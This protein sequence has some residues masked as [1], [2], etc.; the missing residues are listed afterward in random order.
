MPPRSN[1]TSNG[2]L[3]LPAPPKT[4][5]ASLAL[6]VALCCLFAMQAFFLGQLSPWP[7]L[8]GLLL[9]FATAVTGPLLRE[10]RNINLRG[11]LWFVPLT[12]VLTKA[13]F[14]PGSPW[15]DVQWLTQIGQGMVSLFRE[16]LL[17][18]AAA[19]SQAAGEISLSAALFLL[20][21][22]L[23]WGPATLA[24]R[25]ALRLRSW[26]WPVFTTLLLLVWLEPLPTSSFFFLPLV[27][28]AVAVFLLA[29][30]LQRRER[31]ESRRLAHDRRDLRRAL[32][33]SLLIVL[34]L[35]LLVIPWAVA[36]FSY[37]QLTLPSLPAFTSSSPE[38]STGGASGFPSIRPTGP[39]P[40]R[41]VP[42]YH[43]PPLDM[44]ES[45]TRWAVAASTVI[46]LGA[47]ALMGYFLLRMGKGFTVVYM[48]ATGAF[49]V[50]SLWLLPPVL[51][52]IMG[53]FFALL[54]EVWRGIRA[55]FGLPDPTAT[56]SVAATT[57]S[58]TTT[59]SGGTDSLGQFLAS[60]LTF[61]SRYAVWATILG[62]VI[63][64]LVA[65][66]VWR[67]IARTRLLQ[68]A[69]RKRLAANEPSQG[70]LPVGIF[71]LYFRLLA[72]LARMGW[73]RQAM[74]TPYEYARRASPALP[75]L[76]QPFRGIT[77]AFV[78]ARY[79]GREPEAVQEKQLGEELEQA[80]HDTSHPQSK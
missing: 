3:L 45:M 37:A 65:F 6:P 33:W 36:R 28:L 79:G 24:M 9:L 55:A 77:E 32:R 29:T 44:P 59:A 11:W 53:R 49:L 63:F 34:P 17:F 73:A 51:G 18:Q 4:S 38:A 27:I 69:K 71:A 56:P 72:F 21:G 10:Y 61:I 5:L 14:F 20:L 52:P 30:H 64:L 7:L 62:A 2:N 74:E 43:L 70:L 40:D 57:L 8:W 41:D 35:L 31:W 76:E 68:A 25:Y 39:L 26:G 1:D 60:L 13:L 75:W 42:L 58:A 48:I 16:G 47:A 22:V 46:L 15:D 50:L 80:A 23:F 66:F 12:L 78:L 67:S 54:L 19:L